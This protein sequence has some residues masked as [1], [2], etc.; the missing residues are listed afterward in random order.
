MT[1]PKVSC[2]NPASKVDNALSFYGKALLIETDDE[3]K[4]QSYDT[5]VC[6]FDKVYNSVKIN[7]YYSMT[8]GRHIRSFLEYL[9]VNTKALIETSKCRSLKKFIEKYPEF[10]LSDDTYI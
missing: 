4:L 9:G 8:T 6:V 1:Y 7:G 5:I 3:I 10:K 2:L